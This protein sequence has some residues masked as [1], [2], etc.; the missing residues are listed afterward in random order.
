[1]SNFENRNPQQHPPNHNP[2]TGAN[3][4]DESNG[5]GPNIDSSNNSGPKHGS[6]GQ[7]PGGGLGGGYQFINK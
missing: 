2:G 7:M 5:A 4:A 1:M 3:G 6:S